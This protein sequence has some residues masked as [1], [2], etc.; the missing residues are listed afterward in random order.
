MSGKCGHCGASLKGKRS[1]ALY[2][3][4]ACR[5]AAYRA[6]RPGGAYSRQCEECGQWFTAGTPAGRFCSSRCRVRAYRRKA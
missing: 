1:D 4:E 3:S 2:C 5:V 6:R